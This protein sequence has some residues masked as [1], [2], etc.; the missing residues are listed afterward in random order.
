MDLSHWVV[1]VLS[2]HVQRKP[3]KTASEMMSSGLQFKSSPSLKLINQSITSIQL[4]EGT[5]TK[6][7]Q[8]GFLRDMS[9]IYQFAE[10]H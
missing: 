1:I 9:L 6:T 3:I 2:A 10:N 8:V 7:Q 5:T 4:G